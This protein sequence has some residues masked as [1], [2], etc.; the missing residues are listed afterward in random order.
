MPEKSKTPPKKPVKK[1]AKKKK[2]PRKTNGVGRPTV[3]KKKLEKFLLMYSTTN[4]SW[5]TVCDEVGLSVGAVWNHLHRNE[6][7]MKRYKASR[8]IK[9]H[10]FIEELLD[11]ADDSE[12]DYIERKLKS[13]EI[14]IL[15]DSENIQRSK[16]RIETRRWMASK[17]IPRTYGDRVHQ[18]HSGKIRVP[19]N[20]PRS[21][22]QEDLDREIDE[23]IELRKQHADAT[24]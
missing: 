20:D 2:R 19:D 4:K 16:L 23:L 17:F 7:F 5:V 24:T 9:S 1:R 14:A 8:E 6:E 15:L 3:S 21:L 12:N 18:E 11:I 22:S 13:G 10:V